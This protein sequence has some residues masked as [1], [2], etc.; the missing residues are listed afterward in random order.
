MPQT[1]KIIILLPLWTVDWKERGHWLANRTTTHRMQLG[2]DDKGVDINPSVDQVPHQLIS[3][4]YNQ[5]IWL[6]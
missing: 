2:S 5:I 4:F 6:T 3:R 1:E